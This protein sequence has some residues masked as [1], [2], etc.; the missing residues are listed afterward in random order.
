MPDGAHELQ[1]VDIG[2]RD[3]ERLQQGA[4]AGS[5]IARAVYDEIDRRAESLIETVEFHEIRGKLGERLGSV[6]TARMYSRSI[7]VTTCPGWASV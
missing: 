6:L 2:F 3:F 1:H 7:A 4:T 5:R